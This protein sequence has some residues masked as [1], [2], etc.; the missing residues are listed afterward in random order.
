MQRNAHGSYISSDV[1]YLLGSVSLVL[2]I[3][4]HGEGLVIGN[5]LSDH[6]AKVFIFPCVTFISFFL[7]S[8]YGLPLKLVTW[9]L[10]TLTKKNMYSFFLNVLSSHFWS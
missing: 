4:Q 9:K 1:S 3:G 10:H 7:G 8:R 2:L 6:L 5:Y